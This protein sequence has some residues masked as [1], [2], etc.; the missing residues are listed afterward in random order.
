MELPQGVNP[1]LFGAVP[2]PLAETGI[3]KPAGYTPTTRKEGHARPVMLWQ[4][5][6]RATALDWL[7]ATSRLA[8]PGAGRPATDSIQLNSNKASRP[9]VACSP[10]WRTFRD[11]TQKLSDILQQ[12]SDCEKLT[13]LW[14]TTAAAAEFAPL[15]KGEYAFRIVAGE[16]FTRATRTPGYKLTLEVA[17]GEFEGRRALVRLLADAG[18]AADDE[19]R[20]GENRR[21]ATSHN[22]TAVAGLAFS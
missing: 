18:R 14:K 7:E 6:D 9:E 1:K 15:P 21:R 20:P 17:E 4:L 3:I 8:G 12:G 19:T 11:S 22:G 10:F 13:S 5:S 16:L 2:G